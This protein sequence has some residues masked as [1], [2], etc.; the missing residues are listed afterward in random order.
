MYAAGLELYVVLTLERQ[1][2]TYSDPVCEG[3][4]LSHATIHLEL[5]KHD[6]I[7]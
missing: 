2:S 4:V 3:Y 6:V 5:T 7:N 1:C